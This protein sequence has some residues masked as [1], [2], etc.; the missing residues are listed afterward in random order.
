VS[1]AL[2]DCISIVDPEVIEEYPNPTLPT[3]VFSRI[4]RLDE[5]FCI[6][7]FPFVLPLPKIQVDAVLAFLR[8]N[9]KV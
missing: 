7:K 5:E 6:T 3:I 4:S 2:G 1:P 9:C 8:A